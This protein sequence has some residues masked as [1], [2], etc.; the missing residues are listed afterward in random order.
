MLRSRLFWK[1]FGSFCLVILVTAAVVEIFVSRGIEAHALAGIEN[2]L[3]TRTLLLADL[4][5]DDLAAAAGDPDAPPPA[6]LQERVERLGAASG[7]RFT[8]IDAGGRVLADSEESP[9]GMDNHG[10]RPEVM[11]A[12]A[13]GTGSAVRYSLTLRTRM[14]Y[15]ARSV[16][17]GDRRLG[18]VRAALPLAAVDDQLG[19]FRSAVTFGALLAAAF[20]LL[21][22]AAAAGRIIRPLNALAEQARGL[23]RGEKRGRV[24]APGRDEVAELAR[25]FASMADELN[26]RL[27]RLTDERNK[28]EAILAGMVEGVVAVNRE[29]RV[30]HMNGVAGRLLG[31]DPEA[32]IGRPIWEVA[33]MPD[34]GEAVTRCIEENVAVSRESHQ[35]GPDGERIIELYGSPLAGD[36]GPAGAVLVLH[37]VTELRRLESVRRDF[38]ANVSH[39]LKTP[40]TAIRGLVET[41]EDDQAMDADTRRRFL[42][43]IGGQAE[44]LAA[45][46]ADLLA[47]SQL[48]A[49]DRPVERERLDL[50]EVVR[51]A[52]G[53]LA[54]AADRAGLVYEAEMPGSPLAVL[55]ERL[56]LERAVGNLL[57]NAIKYTPRGGRISLRLERAGR[58]AVV[59]VADTGIGIEPRHHKR[60]F[61][62]FYRV[63][64]ARSRA[65]GGTGLG[66]AIV[67]HVVLSHGGRVELDS[68]PGRGSRFRLYLPLAT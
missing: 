51:G 15:L 54:T 59:E 47:L 19:R 39:E 56:A 13:A 41:M 30:L 27:A 10:M 42:A 63:D 40:L 17:S 34:V 50:G 66:L 68:Q 1:L 16:R 57:D 5:R 11:A 6:A 31:A 65:L 61:E 45:Q 9:A 35:T 8:I 14:M 53:A 55:G 22:G 46:V 38:V 25:S 20:A 37:E 48:E 7:T 21:V 3:S 49:G 12:A 44:R 67:K 26:D 2:S 18:T 62:R 52:F 23:A 32:S 24:I 36:G 64:K 28:L 29:E 33:R 60:I 58:E 43:K 4:A